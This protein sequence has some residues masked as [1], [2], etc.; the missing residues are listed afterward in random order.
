M[1]VL[2]SKTWSKKNQFLTFWC[3]LPLFHH[4]SFGFG[5]MKFLILTAFVS[6]GLYLHSMQCIIILNAE[7][8]W[9]NKF[10]SFIVLL[11]SSF[12]VSTSMSISEWFF[13]CLLL[14]LPKER[15]EL[16]FYLLTSERIISK[17]LKT[18]SIWNRDAFKQVYLKRLGRYSPMYGCILYGCKRM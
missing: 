9:C 1:Y 10:D 7:M 13:F 3:N 16:T 11:Y 15:H 8:L 2:T 17:M 4:S 12:C 14:L 5:S 18:I 6:W